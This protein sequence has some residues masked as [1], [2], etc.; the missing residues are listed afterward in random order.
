MKFFMLAIIVLSIYFSRSC[1]PL[2]LKSFGFI[3][4]VFLLPCKALVV[5]LVLTY[6]DANTS[7]PF[8]IWNTFSN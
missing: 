5:L 4:Y 2:V 7:S 1:I 8:D 6:F 3:K